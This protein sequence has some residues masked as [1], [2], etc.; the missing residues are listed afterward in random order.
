MMS[1]HSHSNKAAAKKP[2]MGLKSSDLKTSAAFAQFTPSPNTW[3]GVTREF[4]NPTPMMEPTR[5]CELDAGMPRY[6][7]PRF[8]MMAASSSE[9]TMANPA[10][11][12]TL[13]TSSTGRRDTM[14][15]ATAPLDKSTPVRLRIPDK[16]TAKLGFKEWV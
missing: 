10:P 15:Y 4:A 6:Q 7:V 1:L 11:E 9:N 12:P 14:L 2:N 16:T 8:Q 5:V 3:P 13:S